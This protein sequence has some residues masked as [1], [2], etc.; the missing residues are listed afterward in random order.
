M[1]GAG[2][3]ALITGASEGIGRELCKLFARDAYDL[4]VVARNEKKLKE[5]TEELEN[6]HGIKVRVVP[7]DLS[8]PSAPDEIFE[9][10]KAAEVLV[11]VLVN[12]AGYAVYGAFAESELP[13]QVDMLQV[14]VVAPT[15]LTGLFLPGMVERGRGKILNLGS[16]GSF[17]ACP[18]EAVYAA[19][20]AYVLSFSDALAEE[21][22][23]TGVSV[24]TLCPGATETQFATRSKTENALVWKVGLMSAEEVAKIGYDTLMSNK[25]SVVAGLT[26][27]G[28][29]FSTRM[30]PRVLVTKITKRFL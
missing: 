29:I 14:L 4:V 21:L 27:K 20:K 30:V 15:K 16:I 10:L 22:T 2:Q 11:D 9:G 18:C 12:N 13:A 25:R 1:A 3:T 28:M 7:K 5:L 23:G 17:M 8:S 24:T 26:N 6:K 19:S